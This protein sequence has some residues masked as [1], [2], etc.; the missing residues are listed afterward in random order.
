LQ[1]IADTFINEP[2]PFQNNHPFM[3]FS[4]TG[5]IQTL[6]FIRARIQPTLGE[7]TE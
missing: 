1:E 2:L 4:H 7:I 6:N 5:Q 3:S